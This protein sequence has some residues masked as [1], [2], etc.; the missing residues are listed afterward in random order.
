ML[1]SLQLVH[2][3][4]CVYRVI[5]HARSWGAREKRRVT[6]V[7]SVLSQLNHNSIYAQ[8]K[9]SMNQLFYNILPMEMYDENLKYL[10]RIQ[11]TV[12]SR[13]QRAQQDHDARSR[14]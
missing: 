5:M 9:L 6:L 11:V 1:P 14:Y 8:L 3:L 4:A 12:C 13:H 2:A 7:S 10:N